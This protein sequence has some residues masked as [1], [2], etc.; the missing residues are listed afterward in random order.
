MTINM[1]LLIFFLSGILGIICFFLQRILSRIS[2]Y[3]QKINE[4]TVMIA[5][6]K[7]SIN[8]LKNAA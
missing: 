2:A 7:E 5:V 8:H 4:N 1:D 3:E 6:N